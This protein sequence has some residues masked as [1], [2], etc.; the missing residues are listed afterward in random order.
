MRQALADKMQSNA[1]RFQNHVTP[2]NR[3]SA[4]ESFRLYIERV[5]QDGEHLGTVEVQAASLMLERQIEL[6][7]T[8]TPQILHK[9]SMDFV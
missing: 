1:S 8:M 7:S 2:R 5:R 6:V 9:C 4:E 3:L